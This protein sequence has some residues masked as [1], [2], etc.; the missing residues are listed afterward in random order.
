M[1]QKMSNNHTWESYEGE[2]IPST[3]RFSLGK[4]QDYLT[5]TSTILDLGCGIGKNTW[6]LANIFSHVIGLDISQDAIT[7]ANQEIL[8]KKVSNVVFR[9]E[10]AQ[11]MKSIANNSIDGIL[12][13]ALITVLS[14]ESGHEEID[15][16]LRTF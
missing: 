12:A 7:I 11:E 9:T 13:I 2:K 5:P 8:K 10:N 1:K 14:Q 3:L 6:I 16:Q 15:M 4:L